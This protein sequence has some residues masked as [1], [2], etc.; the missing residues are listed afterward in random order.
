[1]KR[2]TKKLTQKLTQCD[3]CLSADAAGVAVERYT[4]QLGR[5]QTSTLCVLCARFIRSLGL[6]IE[7][8]GGASSEATNG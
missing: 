4:I 8:A 5:P 6:T 3:C 2:P 1:V 7:K